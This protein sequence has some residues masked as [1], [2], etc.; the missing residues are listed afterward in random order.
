MVA[1]YLYYRATVYLLAKWQWSEQIS[2]LNSHSHYNSS[3]FLLDYVI[4]GPY[5]CAKA[6]VHF[7]YIVFK[8][9]K[10]FKESPSLSVAYRCCS[11]CKFN[12]HLE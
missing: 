6:K 12:F 4:S 10:E 8:I 3:F 5:F 11:I 7:I 9:T 1:N 2:Q